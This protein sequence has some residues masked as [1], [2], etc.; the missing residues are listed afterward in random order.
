MKVTFEAGGATVDAHDLGPLLRLAPAEVPEKMRLGEIAS[1]SEAG[2]DEDAGRTRL[3]FWYN[4]LRVRL[5]CDETGN[6]IKT[7]RSVA[8]NRHRSGNYSDD[9]VSGGT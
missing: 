6:V 3:T 5:V 1:Q 7:S 8:T 9:G 2:V 4:G